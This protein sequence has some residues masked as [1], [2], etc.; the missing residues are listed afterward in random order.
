MYTELL[1]E[2]GLQI[3]KLRPK[4]AMKEIAIAKASSICVPQMDA[5]DRLASLWYPLWPCKW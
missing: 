3:D 5:F 4:G 2:S 1:I